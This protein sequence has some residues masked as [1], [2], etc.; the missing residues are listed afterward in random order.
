MLTIVGLVSY[1]NIYACPFVF[2]SEF[3]I[4]DNWRIRQL[5]PPGN[6]LTYSQRP[7]AYATFALNYAVNGYHVAGYHALNVAI[8]IAAALV[9]FAIVRNTLLLESTAE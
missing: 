5:W 8:H 6:W 9:L 7:V 3:R 2:D 4:L 1:A